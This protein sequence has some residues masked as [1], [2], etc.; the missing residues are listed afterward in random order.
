MTRNRLESIIYQLN[1]EVIYSDNK[2]D[3]EYLKALIG[4]GNALLKN[5]E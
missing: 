3:V 5:Y 4:W 1:C 2:K